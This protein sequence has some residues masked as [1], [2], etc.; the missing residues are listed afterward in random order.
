MY[1]AITEKRNN[2]LFIFGGFGG[3]VLNVYFQQIQ[4]NYKNNMKK[5][6]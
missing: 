2:N 4:K 1:E 6:Q 3:G 5:Y